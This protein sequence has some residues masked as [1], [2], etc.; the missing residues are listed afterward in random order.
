MEFTTKFSAAATELF[1]DGGG[2]SEKIYRT[3]LLD[4]LTFF[5]VFLLLEYTGYFLQ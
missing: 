4:Y 2:E 5:T 3:E 1:E